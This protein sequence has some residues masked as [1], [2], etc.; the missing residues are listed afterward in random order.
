M[1]KIQQLSSRIFNLLIAF[2]NCNLRQ[3]L[4]LEGPGSLKEPGS[5]FAVVFYAGDPVAPLFQAPVEQP[6]PDNA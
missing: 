3:Y 5:L 2:P 6:I 1:R 4:H